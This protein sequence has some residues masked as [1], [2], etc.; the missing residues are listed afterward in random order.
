M[1]TTASKRKRPARNRNTRYEVWTGY[2]S[3]TPEV[4]S[5]CVQTECRKFDWLDDAWEYAR[6]LPEDA[7]HAIVQVTKF[8]AAWNWNSLEIRS[9]YDG[10][11][12]GVYPGSVYPERRPL[13]PEEIRNMGD[14]KNQT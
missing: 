7:M 4:P 9:R 6:N 1:T 10:S 3:P 2:R 12:C 13:T 14:W 5:R 11:W 8:S